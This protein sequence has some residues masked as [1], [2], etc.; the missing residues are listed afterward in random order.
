[1]SLVDAI[2]VFNSRC[3]FPGDNARALAFA[4]RHGTLCTVGSDAHYPMEIG[5]AV[6]HLPQNPMSG[7]EFL[8]GL[9][10]AEMVYQNTPLL[11]LLRNMM[12]WTVREMKRAGQHSTLR[13]GS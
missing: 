7:A 12:D 9:A 5:R 4:R 3:A 11:M 2:E 1:M 10:Q 13:K 8:A 6:L